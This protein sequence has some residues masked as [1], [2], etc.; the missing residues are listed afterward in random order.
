MLIRNYNDMVL[1]LPC[2]QR[3]SD[4]AV[5]ASL[6]IGDSDKEGVRCGIITFD[7]Q[8]SH[9]DTVSFRE[10]VA[11]NGTAK[12]GGRYSATGDVQSIHYTLDASSRVY[13]IV[14]HPK[15][16]ARSAFAALEE[17]QASFERDFGSR[18]ATAPENGLSRV[19]KPL[20]ND[21]LT[22]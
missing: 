10:Q 5:L 11:S 14:T 15:F 20:M 12:P 9:F 21:I 8:L 2:P 18:M 13:A 22:K 7:L 4:K 19:S 16:S 6:S 17:L 3:F 1:T